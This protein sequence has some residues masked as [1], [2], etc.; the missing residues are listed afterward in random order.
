MSLCDHNVPSNTNTNMTIN[1]HCTEVIGQ[2]AIRIR[3]GTYV[4]GKCQLPIN[5]GYKRGTILNK[6]QNKNICPMQY[7]YKLD[8]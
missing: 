2:K 4:C 1:I 6:L 7:S 5:I 8:I 3:L